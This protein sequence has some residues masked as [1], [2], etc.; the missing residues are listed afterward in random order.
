M[1]RVAPLVV[2]LVLALGACV[3]AD[4]PSRAT[5]SRAADKE[6]LYADAALVPTREGE[7]V[8]REVA[9]AGEIEAAVAVAMD[10]PHVAADVELEVPPRVAVAVRAG[11]ADPE[12]SRASVQALARAIVKDAEVVVILSAPHPRSPDPSAP[13]RPVAWLLLSLLGLGVSLGIGIER[14]RLRMARRRRR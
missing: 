7:R 4:A 8:R 5:P 9:L 2:L 12:A 13:A 10:T 3:Q 1:A 14:L 6:A 11:S